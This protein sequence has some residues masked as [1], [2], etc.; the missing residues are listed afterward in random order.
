MATHKKFSEQLFSD[1]SYVNDAT[2]LKWIY[3]RGNI[4]KS[5]AINH[6]RASNLSFQ[7]L[8]LVSTLGTEYNE[9]KL[10]QN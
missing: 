3:V 7:L 4:G 9:A 5:N 2:I 1:I 10:M 6:P 8:S